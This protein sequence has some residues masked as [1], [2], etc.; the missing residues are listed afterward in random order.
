MTR[1]LVNIFE[2]NIFT[3]SFYTSIKEYLK[4]PHFREIHIN[5]VKEILNVGKKGIIVLEVVSQN[6]K[7]LTLEFK[8]LE[9]EV[10]NIS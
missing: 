3:S 1:N 7:D 9:S 10:K 2:R 5:K 6:F 4:E 8:D